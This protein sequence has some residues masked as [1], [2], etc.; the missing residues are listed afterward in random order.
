MTL[1]KANFDDCVSGTDI[2][3][4]GSTIFCIILQMTGLERDLLRGGSF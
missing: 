3:V 4:G 2:N 1:K